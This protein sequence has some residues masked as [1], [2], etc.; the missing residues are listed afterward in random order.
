[1]QLEQ[2][3][4]GGHIAALDHGGIA[5]IVGG[6]TTNFPDDYRANPRLKFYDSTDAT[7]KKV[8]KNIPHNCKAIICMRFVDHEISTPLV[9][10]ARRL[11]IPI[12]HATAT[13]EAKTFI[14]RMLDPEHK[15]I[16][17]EAPPM[18]VVTAT[19][20]P[21]ETRPQRP[22]A[23]AYTQALA[24]W[25][26]NE[27]EPARLQFTD[28]KGEARTRIGGIREEAKRLLD[29]ALARSIKGND[30]KEPDLDYMYQALYG[31]LKMMGIRSGAELPAWVGVETPMLQSENTRRVAEVL[32]GSQHRE[33]LRELAAKGVN[34]ESVSAGEASLKIITA[35]E[36]TM[37]QAM[38]Y[39]DQ[40]MDELKGLKGRLQH[41]I[42][43][44]EKI[45]HF[46][47][48]KKVMMEGLNG[49]S[50]GNGVHG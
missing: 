48:V 50:N 24:K 25:I 10:E 26:W 23:P 45:A 8:A 15:P 12:F 4:T 37:M 35:M 27:V 20:V 18:P 38:L 41:A 7:T 32:E 21:A 2:A 30:G 9:N 47:M 13:G 6:R 11:H 49:R 14:D 33:H 22:S 3:V 5:I 29:L 34:L 42:T 43:L 40:V 44:E 19:T 31:V 28:V 17:R 1:M 16:V 36:E 39:M 46:E